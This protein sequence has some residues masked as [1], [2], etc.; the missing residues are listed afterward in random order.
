[1]DGA[2]DGFQEGRVLVGA[3]LGA[4]VLF[5]GLGLLDDVG[6]LLSFHPELGQGRLVGKSLELELGRLGK[7]LGESE[8]DEDGSEEGRKVGGA[9]TLLGRDS[10]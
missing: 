2:G 8:G 3:L 5:A 7:E 1:M 6:G 10:R 4:I 9:L